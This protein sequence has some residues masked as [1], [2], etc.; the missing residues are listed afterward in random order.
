MTEEGK[1]RDIEAEDSGMA[2]ATPRRIGSGG[3]VDAGTS[4]ELG[5]CGPFTWS[6]YGALRDT[7]GIGGSA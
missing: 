7:S 5:S 1:P 6:G 3:G 2:A 4:R